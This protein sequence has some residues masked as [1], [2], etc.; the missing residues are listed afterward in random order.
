MSSGP[1]TTAKKETVYNGPEVDPLKARQASGQ[2]PSSAKETVH[3]G[4][5]PDFIKNRFQSSAETN[6]HIKETVH[7]GDVPDFITNRL[8][9]SKAPQIDTTK[10]TIHHGPIPAMFLR[11]GRIA[12]D[13]VMPDRETIYEGPVSRVQN[14]VDIKYVQTREQPAQEQNAAPKETVYDENSFVAKRVDSSA[15]RA[16]VT[17]L[18]QK[19]SVRFFTVA[20][21]SIAEMYFHWGNLAICISSG[22]M[23]A[24]FIAVGIYTFKMNLKA[25]LFAIGIYTCSTLFML[26][27]GMMS[28]DGIFLMIPTLISRGFMIYNL[29]RTYGL[30]VD[31]HLLEAEAW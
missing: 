26:V 4:E 31:L 7:Q 21:L 16:L 19:A 29:L 11:L 10:E 23:F 9:R 12:S 24:T 8:T 14:A 28:P 22:I 27:N 3:E 6:G 30:L 13:I 2:P 17:R 25:L 1:A 18:V 15:S 20:V 5:V